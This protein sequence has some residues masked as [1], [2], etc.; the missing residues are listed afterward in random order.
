MSNKR[1]T[2][3]G[4]KMV[5]LG[6]AAVGKS[7]ILLR[8]T[9][10]SFSDFGESTIGAAFLTTTIETDRAAVKLELWDT[11]GQER[12]NALAPMFY[13]NAAAALVVYDIT[14]R[15]SLER[16]RRWIQELQSQPTQAPMIVLVGNKVDMEHLRQVPTDMAAELAKEFNVTPYECSAKTNVN[17]QEIFHFVADGLVTKSSNKSPSAQPSSIVLTSNE[18]EQKK[19]CC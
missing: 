4:G 5:V 17:I 9:K 3:V 14:S 19:G 2:Q 11:A 18:P 6:D 15:S 16:A 13:R 12:Y 10:N 1:R 8:L 7:S